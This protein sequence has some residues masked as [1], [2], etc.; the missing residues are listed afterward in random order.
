VPLLD[1]LG[2]EEQTEDEVGFIIVAMH[3]SKYDVAKV[4]E[5]S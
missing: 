3:C 1:C 4:L 5:L 2:Y